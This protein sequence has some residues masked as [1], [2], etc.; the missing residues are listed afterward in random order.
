MP[1]FMNV[2]CIIISFLPSILNMGDMYISHLLAPSHYRVYSAP[3]K[4]MWCCVGTGMEN[5]GKY[6]QFIYT[7]DTA[8]NALYVNLFIPSELNWKEKKIKI[9]QETDF[10]NE[11]GTT[12][13]V[14]PSKATQF[15]LL[16]RYP[17]W[18]EQGKMQ[19]VCNG[20]DYAKS[21]QPGSYIAIDRQWSKGDVV[22]VKT[23]MTV[24]I[25]ELP[26][27]T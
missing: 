2:P 3:G 11:E 10:P 20:V 9:V 24:R 13:T 8:D 7:H 17:S 22:E 18:V 14:N 4:A 21:A 15:K 5:H 1:I 27:C 26:Q 23:P 25:E 16:I 6:G 19:V 12:L